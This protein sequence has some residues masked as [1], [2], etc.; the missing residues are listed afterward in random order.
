[1]TSSTLTYAVN[2]FLDQSGKTRFIVTNRTTGR[3]S[4]CLSLFEH[5]QMI[6]GKSPNSTSKSLFELVYF[7][8]WAESTGLDL[9]IILL[10]G[11]GISDIHIRQ[12]SHW[13]RNYKTKR[14]TTLTP[15]AF[16]S[17]ITQCA[18]FCV[19]CG[20]WEAN[21]PSGRNSAII[22]HTADQI[23]RSGWLSKSIRVRNKK[24]A[25]DLTEEE[26]YLIERFLRPDAAIE[27]GINPEVAYRNYLIWHLAIEMG[28]RISEILALRLQ[29]CPQHNKN[30]V[31]VV[32]I[33]ERGSAHS[34]PRGA[35]APRP[36]TLSRD[37][38]FIVADSPLPRLLQAYISKYRCRK[39]QGGGRQFLLE[40]DFLVVTHKTADPLSIASAM[41]IADSIAMQSGVENFHWHIAR[42]AFF[43]RAYAAVAANNLYFNDLVYF[44]GWSDDKSL[45]LYTQ[46]AIR[47]RAIQTLSIWQQGNKWESLTK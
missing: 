15:K 44:G 36:K 6:S 42:H 34:D 1:M 29:D 27:R 19:W 38:G 40:H 11:T 9:D 14:E 46:R 3:P 2:R 23:I 12:F 30:Y 25:P 5:D 17:I 28:L 32:R 24:A 8:T 10:N 16:N 41:S 39:M 47:N 22:N 43:N 33:E 4:I 18:R 31:S 26:I 20:K 13:L 21:R 45:N 7:Y 35:Y 37:L